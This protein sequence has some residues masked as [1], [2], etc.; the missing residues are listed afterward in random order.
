MNK[1]Q[2]AIRVFD[3]LAEVYQEKFMD[4]SLYQDSLDLL[5]RLLKKDAKVLELA[6]GPG[7]VTRYLLS[8]RPD[9][10]ILGTDLAPNM[11]DLARANNPDADFQ[12]MDCRDLDTLDVKYDGIICAFGL[13]YLSKEEAVKF[14]VDA[15]KTLSPEGFLFLSTMEDDYEKSGWQKPSSGEE[16]LSAYIHFHQAD[17][18]ETALKESSFDIINMH[19]VKSPEQKEKTEIDLLITAQTKTI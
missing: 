15:G 18:L 2:A 16:G 13:P 11:L 17:Y 7:N 10:R 14:I 9:L 1:T 5:C 3:Q 4:V 8:K 6:C 12:L 19:R